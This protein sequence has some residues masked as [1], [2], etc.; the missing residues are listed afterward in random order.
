MTYAYDSLGRMS[1]VT[2]PFTATN[3]NKDVTYSYDLHGWTTGV[4]T[5]SFREEL[6]Y[7]DG[8]GTPRYNGNISSIRWYDRSRTTRG[9]KL[10]YDDANRLTQAAYGQGTNLSSYTPSRYSF[11]IPLIC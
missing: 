10:T 1:R 8:P 11:R 5:N 2:R 9:Y 7:A 3:V 6:F 4:T